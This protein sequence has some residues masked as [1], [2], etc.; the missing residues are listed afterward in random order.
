MEEL[1]SILAK[2]S[3]MV[4]AFYPK[5]FAESSACA[6]GRSTSAKK[7]GMFGGVGGVGM[8]FFF[9]FNH[10]NLFFHLNFIFFFLTLF[11]LV[12]RMSTVKYLLQKKKI[13][14][15]KL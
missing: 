4:A 12:Y 13:A 7:F 6:C 3:T 14:I 1:D 15:R 2:A 11:V 8:C 5:T 9:N 10:F